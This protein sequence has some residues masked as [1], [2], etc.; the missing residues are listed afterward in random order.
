MKRNHIKAIF[1]MLA[2]SLLNLGFIPSN[3]P[4]TF[5][6]DRKLRR[7]E[8]YWGLHFDRHVEEPH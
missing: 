7:S 1:L 5:K 8:S 4:E 2:I 3:Q 6:H